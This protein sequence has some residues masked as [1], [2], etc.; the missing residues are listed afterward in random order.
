[1]QFITFSRK[2]GTGGSEIAKRV[3]DELG[4]KCHDTDAIEAMAREM[5]FLDDIRGVDDKP[6]TGFLRYFTNKSD[7]QI[8]RLNSVIYE[9][10]SRGSAVFLGR[11]SHILL[12]SYE[13]ALHIRVTASM[14]YRIQILGRRGVPRE[15]AERLIQESDR[16]R[17][18][19]IKLFFNADWENPELYDMV[20]NMDHI[21]EDLAIDTIL[22]LARS[23]EIQAR[24]TD[25]MQSLEMISL[26]QRTRATLIEAEAFDR[27]FSFADVSVPMPGCVRLTGVVTSEANKDLI[28][29]MMRKV[30]GVEV[31]ENKITLVKYTGT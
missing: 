24:S 22:H 26:L 30:K 29:K 6:P 13:C 17:G 11:G 4:Y 8:D 25:V 27:M 5:G 23:E 28:E 12:R 3:A 18:G 19:F 7:I 20:L 10:A 9:L 31:V 14:A 21:S 1:M 15:A 16:E 2:M